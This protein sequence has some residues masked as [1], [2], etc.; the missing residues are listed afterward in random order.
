[1]ELKDM[2]LSTLAEIEKIQKEEPEL[3]EKRELE[4]TKTFKVEEEISSV[5]QEEKTKTNVDE[6]KYLESLKDRLL[7]LFEGLQSSNVE[8]LEAKL[9]LTLNFLEFL[10]A[11]IEDR[12]DNDAKEDK[13]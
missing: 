11:S 1:M 2:V 10:L 3:K 13:S 9:D 6:I 5:E 4:I 7:V 8:K 12:L